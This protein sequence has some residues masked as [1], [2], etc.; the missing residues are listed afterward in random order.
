[1]DQ[2]PRQR[3]ARVL[4]AVPQSHDRDVAASE[5]EVTSQGQGQSNTPAELFEDIKAAAK[6]AGALTPVEGGCPPEVAAAER[7]R[8]HRPDGTV[9][10][11]E[12][13]EFRSGLE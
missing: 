6:V 5:P 4:P 1:M 8:R 7:G 11:Y 3:N 2:P 10:E 13:L 12:R 9:E